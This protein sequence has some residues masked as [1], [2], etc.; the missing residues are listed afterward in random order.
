MTYRE[1]KLNAKEHKK[2][3]IA[4]QKKLNERGM[5]LT[6]LAHEIN[7][8]RRSIYNF[9]SDSSKNPSKFLAGKLATYL[10]IKPSEYKSK[11]AFFVIPLMIPLLLIPLN[12]SADEVKEYVKPEI[13]YVREID[14]EAIENEVFG[15]EYDT[16]FVPAYYEAEEEYIYDSDI[17]LTE[18]E[19]EMIQKICER[20]DLSYE[21]VLAIMEKESGY[22][23]EA[24]N[25][26]GSCL[27]IMQ[28]NTRYHDIDNPFDLIENV[29]V[30]TDYLVRLFE[31][32]EDVC[33]VLDAFNGRD[34]KGN[35]EKGVVS[36][37][38][39]NITERA[40]AIE[41]AHGK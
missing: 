7:V 24:I 28:L 13:E 12:A 2:F 8:S 38:A 32:N 30:G 39:R 3:C 23:A 33:Y 26:T 11:G 6:D 35:F 1:I 37:Y 34:A 4:M 40:K 31:E 10:N 18:N 17:P 29:E 21:L 19:Q 14:H 15:V 27:G 36:S 20:K 16:D 9:I 25:N 41:K 5:N 22:D